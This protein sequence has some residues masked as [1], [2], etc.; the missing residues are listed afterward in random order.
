MAETPALNE[1]F[2]DMLRALVEAEVEFLIVGAHALAVHG[3][4]RATGDIDVF[5]RPSIENARRVMNGERVPLIF[6]TYCSAASWTSSSVAGG[7]KLKS[8]RML[9]H[10][11]SGYARRGARCHRCDYTNGSMCGWVRAL[12]YRG[13]RTCRILH[14]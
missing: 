13:P 11:R 10:M 6:W 8:G 9:R 4:P 7:A 14:G 12:R 3:V 1:D 5:V 2:L